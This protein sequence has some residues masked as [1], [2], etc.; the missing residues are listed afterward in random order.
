MRNEEGVS[1]VVKWG[2]GDAAW[3]M[4]LEVQMSEKSG[5]G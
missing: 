3:E 2:N 1:S 4:T 5:R